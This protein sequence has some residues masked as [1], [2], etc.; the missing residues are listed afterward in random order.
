MFLTMIP[1]S[2]SSGGVSGVTQS[3]GFILDGNGA[4]LGTGEKLDAL[5]QIPYNSYVLNTSAYIQDGVTGAGNEISFGIKKTSALSGS[6]TGTDLV[7]GVTASA[8]QT[9]FTFAGDAG[10][11]VY[12]RELA[13]VSDTSG[14][15]VDAN[16]WIFPE[17]TGNSGDINKLQIFMTVVPTS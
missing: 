8:E 14:S 1:F 6:I 7:L 17:I 15:T 16:E 13:S 5:R 2:P 12:F 10:N 4:P 11:R 9:G 3:I